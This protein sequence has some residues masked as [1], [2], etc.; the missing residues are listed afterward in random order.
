MDSSLFIHERGKS[1]TKV[2]LWPNPVSS[3]A[4][5]I[6]ETKEYIF[7]LQGCVSSQASLSIDDEELEAL[8]S[9]SASVARW[10]WSPGF[11]AGEI[12]LQVSPD[13]NASSEVRV[14]GDPALYKLTRHDF[15]TM[16]KDILEDTAALFAL[17][18]FRTSVKRGLGDRVP[19]IARLEFLRS[20]FSQLDRVI[21][22]INERPV[23]TLR[24]GMDIVPYWK[25]QG[26]TTREV[27]ASFRCAPHVILPDH[28]AKRLKH[29]YFPR[30]IRR[31]EKQIVLDIP[32]HRAIMGVLQ[33]WRS[34]LAAIGE[35]LHRERGEDAQMQGSLS[36]WGKRCRILSNGIDRLLQ[37]PLFDQIIPSSGPLSASPVFRNVRG[38]QQFLQLHREITLGLADVRGEF[39]RLPLARTYQ[40]YEMWCFLRIAQACVDAG[41]AE[42]GDVAKLF[43]ENEAKLGIASLKGGAVILF[44]DSISIGFQREYEEYWL[45]KDG[46]GSFSRRMKPDVSVS[47]TKSSKAV[48]LILLDAKYRVDEQLNNALASLHMYRDALVKAL[49]EDER[50]PLVHA[51]Y[52]LT[53]H[54]GNV[55]ADW[56]TSDV[57]SRLFHPAYR[58]TFKFGAATLRPGMSIPEVR[59]VLNKLIE[60]S[61]VSSLS[62]DEHKDKGI[63]EG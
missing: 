35:R 19:A 12:D 15:D 18:G 49:G 39:L 33:S 29:K 14:I 26:A 25:S 20:R 53:P 41:T 47:V 11:Y 27:G 57:Q 50:V 8:R 5:V 9:P 48:K 62:F 28:L 7:E 32:E 31:D 38:Y 36:R 22:E 1:E 3:L 56:K 51:A 58:S 63:R 59:E 6:Q 24:Q 4:G 42:K 34:W 54:L 44:S 16:V 55:G 13:T 37:L 17:S 2:R 40:L 60:D 30:N 21:R 23:R 46:A 45:A 43:D 61:E 10:R 52:I